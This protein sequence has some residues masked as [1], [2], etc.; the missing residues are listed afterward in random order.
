MSMAAVN[1]TR[2]GVSLWHGE[3]CSGSCSRIVNYDDGIWFDAH[4]PR[5][6]QL[7]IIDFETTVDRPLEIDRPLRPT[8]S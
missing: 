7:Q 8:L 1:V 4:H 3:S 6:H 5:H 2:G